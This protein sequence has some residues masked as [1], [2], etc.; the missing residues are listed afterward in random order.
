[1]ATKVQVKSV[2]FAL[3]LRDGNA[4]RGDGERHSRDLLNYKNSEK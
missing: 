3:R 1:M 4:V 2:G